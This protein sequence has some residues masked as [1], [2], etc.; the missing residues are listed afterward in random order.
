[1]YYSYLVLR[2]K[3]EG[4]ISL[5]L[6]LLT[7]L[8][9]LLLLSSYLLRTSQ[10][11]NCADKLMIR[12]IKGNCFITQTSRT[13]N[14]YWNLLYF[15]LYY[16]VFYLKS[17]WIPGFPLRCYQCKTWMKCSFMFHRMLIPSKSLTVNPYCFAFLPVFCAKVPS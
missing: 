1:M 7:W 14:I 12:V 4:N 16:K 8:D 5:E 10:L 17:S 6:L 2:Q 9:K 13:K 15:L 11:K 3:M